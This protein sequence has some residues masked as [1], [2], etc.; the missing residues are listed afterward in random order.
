MF[1]DDDDDDGTNR[2]DVGEGKNKNSV[3][4]R[5][6]FDLFA[7]AAP[8]QGRTVPTATAAV[9]GDGDSADRRTTTTITNT[10]ASADP[11][12]LPKRRETSP[13]ISVTAAKTGKTS[14][15]GKYSI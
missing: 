1:S 9:N 5:N 7:D 14:V 10:M 11:T 8:H 2:T 4:G 15:A 3:A 13:V 12:T 6:V